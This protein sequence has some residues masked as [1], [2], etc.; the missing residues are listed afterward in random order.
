MLYSIKCYIWYIACYTTCYVQAG[1]LDPQY[2][3]VAS[4]FTASEGWEFIH[5]NP[6]PQLWKQP[7]SS[8]WQQ[9]RIW[10]LQQAL[11]AQQPGDIWMW[12]YGRGQPRRVTVAE[13]ELQGKAAISD[14]CTRAADTL[15]RRRDE[16]GDAGVYYRKQAEDASD[17]Y[18]SDWKPILLFSM[19][20]TM[21]Y[22]TCYIQC[23]I[24]C[25]EAI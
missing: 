21:L 15:K 14:A 6:A 4:L 2:A 9:E 16:Q 10:Q 12:R 25:W 13:A 11:Q 19:L 1:L 17:G 22:N 18:A 23:Y 20:Y 5:S 7:G 3:E 24:T 8:G